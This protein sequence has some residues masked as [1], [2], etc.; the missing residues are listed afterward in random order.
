MSALRFPVVL[1]QGVGSSILASLSE[2]GRNDPR[3]T[4][5][6]P[7]PSRFP[8]NEDRYRNAPA[9]PSCTFVAS[10]QGVSGAVRPLDSTM[11]S[12]GLR[13]L[14]DRVPS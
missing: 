4:T 6:K 12:F 13:A 14:R 7:L 5:S 8:S 9:L 3:Q 11:R 1:D 10:L 2:A